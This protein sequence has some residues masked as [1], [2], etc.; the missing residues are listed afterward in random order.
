MLRNLLAKLARI[1]LLV[2]VADFGTALLVRYSPGAT[3]DER[4]LDRRL[5][6]G[7][8]SE[9]R[10]RTVRNADLGTNLLHYLRGLARGDLGY[11][12]SNG[13]PIGALIWDRAPDTLRELGFGLTGAWLL[14]FGLAVPVARWRRAWM[15]DAVSSTAA[16]LLLTLPAALVA[17]LCLAAG[18][19][20]TVV[21]IL[22]LTPKIFRFSRSL[23]IQAY[24]ATHV[25]MAR[26]RGLAER[27]ILWAHVVAPAAPQLAA[28][29]GISASMAIGATIPI[30]AICDVP[31]LGR[32]AWQAA[33]ARDLPV[34]VNLTML[35]AVGTTIAAALSEIPAQESSG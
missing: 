8:L 19:T 10:A 29:I 7:S 18:T 26:A 20:A 30:E 31:G 2:L 27:R 23:L 14:G 3:I 15:Y 35:V 6:E 22:V 9:L 21:L 32:L 1:I 16:G 12:E 13:A 5:G 34:L 33:M 11:S 25:S 28:L 4:E 24:E 17:Y